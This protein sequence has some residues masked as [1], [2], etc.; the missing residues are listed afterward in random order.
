MNVAKLKSSKQMNHQNSENCLYTTLLVFRAFPYQV[1]TCFEDT[2]IHFGQSKVFE[3]RCLWFLV[4]DA[5]LEIQHG[6]PTPACFTV[7]CILTL[8][9]KKW[10]AYA[11][12]HSLWCY[13]LNFE[14]V[15]LSSQ[16]VCMAPDNAYWNRSKY[17]SKK[18]FFWIQ[19]A[20]DFFSNTSLLCFLFLQ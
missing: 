3:I 6:N 13:I 10:H 11:F 1:F 7:M 19:K 4:Y 8:N 2:M 5:C 18:R 16:S 15:R 12:C 20:L 17:L 14:H 9:V